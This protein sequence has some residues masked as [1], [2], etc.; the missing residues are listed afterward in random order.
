MG[1]PRPGSPPRYF[2]VQ[3]ILSDRDA[4]LKA[5]CWENP[6]TCS[7]VIRQALRA[8][9]AGELPAD[10]EGPPPPPPPRKTRAPAARP[11]PAPAPTRPKPAIAPP[12]A[13]AVVE[14]PPPPPAAVVPDQPAEAAEPAAENPAKEKLHRL[15][16][17][18]RDFM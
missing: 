9:L 8:H 3:I 13:I 11:A 12:P 16:L 4:D 5:W 6:D 15:F 10:G 7:A 1:K 2:R 14:D 17:Q 18:N